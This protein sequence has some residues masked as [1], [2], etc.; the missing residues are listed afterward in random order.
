[1][2]IGWSDGTYH[3]DEMSEALSSYKL[4]PI[5]PHKEYDDSSTNQQGFLDRSKKAV[6]ALVGTGDQE[7]Y[8]TWPEKTVKRVFNALSLPGDVLAGKEDPLTA[9]ETGR[10]LDLATAVIGGPAPL[11]N[12]VVKGTLGSMAGVSSK[13]I[14]PAEYELPSN[15]LSQTETRIFKTVAEN[16]GKIDMPGIV[17]SVYAHDPEGGPLAAPG[18]V[19]VLMNRINSKLEEHGLK[20]KGDARSKLFSVVSLE[21]EAGTKNLGYQFSMDKRIIEN[22]GNQISISPLTASIYDLIHRFDGNITSS[23]LADRLGTNIENIRPQISKLN[24]RLKDLNLVVTNQ[25]NNYRILD[26]RTGKSPSK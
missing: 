25:N 14:G 3:E 6:E 8:Q 10:A 22:E 26:L 13:V 4:D 23:A 1:M 18:V 5:L 2:G 24:Q 12:K 7:R 15:L 16:N 20:I 19:R 17:D 21:E 11:V 9:V